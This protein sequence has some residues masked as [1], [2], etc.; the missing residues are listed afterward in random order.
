MKVIEIPRLYIGED[1]KS[2]L[3]YKKIYISE[4]DGEKYLK[5]PVE[6]YDEET[7]KELHG[8]IF[9]LPAKGIELLSK[10]VVE[11]LKQGS[12]EV[13]EVNEDYTVICLVDEE[14]G[15]YTFTVTCD[16]LGED[17]DGEDLISFTYE[18][19]NKRFEELSF[20]ID[21]MIEVA[22]QPLEELVELILKN[23]I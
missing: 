3:I 16:E 6:V 1:L 11:Q 12:K 7:E 2:E 10:K 22:Q 17:E 8:E 18:K 4:K 14:E 9:E 21:L 23:E 20:G 13:E 5:F 15:H 19:E